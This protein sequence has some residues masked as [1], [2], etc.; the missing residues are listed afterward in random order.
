MKARYG[1]SD[2]PSY[3]PLMVCGSLE[4]E[5]PGSSHAA[6]FSSPCMW[7]KW[8]CHLIF[9]LSYTFFTYKP[10]QHLVQQCTQVQ[11]KCHH[12][13]HEEELLCCGPEVLVLL[14]D[15]PCTDMNQV[16]WELAKVAA[17]GFAHRFGHRQLYRRHWEGEEC[18]A[19]AHSPLAR[20]SFRL[21]SVGQFRRGL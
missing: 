1:Q 21:P 19:G 14:D 12:R 9:Y 16:D 13:S 8:S 7:I 15:L 5:R 10:S 18:M 6:D 3:V 20:C 11:L 4:K 17:W 2:V